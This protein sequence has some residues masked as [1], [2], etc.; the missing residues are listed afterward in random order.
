MKIKGDKQLEKLKN[1][2]EVMSDQFD[3]YSKD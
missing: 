2:V 3:E 1:S